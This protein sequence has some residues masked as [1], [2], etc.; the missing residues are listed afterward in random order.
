MIEDDDLVGAANG[1]EAVGDHD[2]RPAPEQAPQSKLDLRLGVAVDIGRRLVEDEY[3]GI[4]HDG[5]G[6][7]DELA[8]ADAQVLAA[9]LEVGVVPVFELDYEAVR[10]DG[11]RRLDHPLLGNVNVVVLDVLPHGAGEEE[12]L[13]EHHVHLARQGRAHHVA[14]IVAVH[15]H[16]ASS[17]LNVVEPGDQGDERRLARAGRANDCDRLPRLDAQAQIVY[18]VLVL[19]VGEAHVPQ[20]DLSANGRQNGSVRSVDHVRLDV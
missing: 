18:D 20:L 11:L 3:L 13:L 1:R 4:G 17:L 12:R 7:A 16:R 14:H 19:F 5:S 8:L 9:L 15:Q 10:V 6:E 2:G